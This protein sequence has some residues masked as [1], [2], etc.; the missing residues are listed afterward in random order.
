MKRKPVKIIIPA[1]LAAVIAGIILWAFN[2][3]KTFYYTGTIEATE[4][5]LS[6]Q[7][8][9]V[10]DQFIAQEG[11]DV[12][13]GQPLVIMKGE[14]YKLNAALA[15]KDFERARSLR[16]SGSI[17]KADFDKL[18]AQR[19][20]AALM[21]DWC[22]IEAPLDATVLQTYREPGELVAPGTTLLTLGDLSTV[23]AYI[24]VE[25]PMLVKLKLDQQVQGFL[26]EL[27][28][29]TFTGRI[30]VIRDKAEFTP[31]NVQTREERARLVFGIKVEFDNPKRLLKPGMSIEVKLPDVQ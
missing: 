28:G 19:D 24:Y 29:Q 1:V 2:L 4:T 17:T 30:T 11:Q 31:K 22:R 23:W 15:Q 16:K 8:M 27:P 12:E 3:K 9:S 7:V 13:K 20:R 5:T 21:V 6:S 25:E 14:D 26:P 10:I 18:K